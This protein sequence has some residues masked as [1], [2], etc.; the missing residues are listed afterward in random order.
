MGTLIKLLVFGFAFFGVNQLFA[1]GNLKLVNTQ[2]LDMNSVETL[3]ILYS[4]DNIVLLESNN[5]NLVLK[6]FMSRNRP[7]YCA[8]I[9]KSQGSITINS[10]MRPWFIRTRIEIYVP[11]TFSEN[12]FV[13]LRSGNLTS[14]YSMN[15]RKIKLS[16]SSGNINI[17]NVSSENA[18][19]NV[20]S[21]N[22]MIN[23][24]QGK[25][26]AFNKSGTIT[27]NDFSG[28]GMFDVKS[29]K[30]NL[31]INDITGDLS[32]SANS[33][34][35]NLTTSENASFI[36]DAD[37]RS[38]NIRAPDLKTQVNTNVQHS[39]GSNPIHKIS[40]KCYSGNINIQ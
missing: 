24:C 19:A 8:N 40:A 35:I 16:V 2:T 1:A 30:I 34:I 12:L 23:S 39:V 36:L 31:T 14:D 15:Y 38:G 7:K 37:V 20:S 18:L 11:K 9:E 5:D 26:N 28:G 10:G 17:N 4:S 33:G 21:G 6:E 25:I 22:I 3:N 32:L 27:V 13:K 29:G